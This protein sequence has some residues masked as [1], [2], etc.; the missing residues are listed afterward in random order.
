MRSWARSYQNCDERRHHVAPK[1]AARTV[2]TWHQYTL[3]GWLDDCAARYPQRP[4]VLTDEIELSY[5]DV[6]A[7]SR[8]LADGLVSLGVRPGDRVGM[9]LANYPEFVAVKFAIARVG[10]IAVPFNY[11]YQ[12]D[13]L[14]YVLA[15][16]GCKVLV[17]MTG[18]QGLDYQSML[19]GV[20]PR[21][22]VVLLDTDGRV[23]ANCL[24]VDDLAALGD[25]NVGA[26]SGFKP[27]PTDPGDMLYT[28]GTTGA[29]KGVLTSH[30]AVLRTAYASALTRAYETV[31]AYC[32]RCPAITCSDTSRVCF[33]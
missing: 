3:A 15:D 32:S 7:Q 18:F 19:D 4:F 9:V 2:S 25:E 8:Q 13:E 29:P 30:D 6:A 12:Q 28:S 24:T 10:A 5:A 23:R 33:L 22:A 17:G 16:S 11:L 20:T 26:S 27:D 1:P 14:R 31:D 21:P